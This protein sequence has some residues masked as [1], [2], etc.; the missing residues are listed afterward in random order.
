MAGL[1][2]DIYKDLK[3][4][5]SLSLFYSQLLIYVEIYLTIRSKVSFADN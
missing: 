5:K 1:N 2:K 3:R 4:E